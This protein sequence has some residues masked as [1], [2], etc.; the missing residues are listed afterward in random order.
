MFYVF[1]RYLSIIDM[2]TMQSMT[3]WHLP[4]TRAPFSSSQ[5]SLIS[6]TISWSIHT[7]SMKWLHL[8]APS[9]L[10][11]F[12]YESDKSHMLLNV[13]FLVWLAT[14]VMPLMFFCCQS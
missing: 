9:T 14:N 8:T 6:T 12:V 3:T 5:P 2:C 11:S 13:F 7:T 1:V 10:S 4:S